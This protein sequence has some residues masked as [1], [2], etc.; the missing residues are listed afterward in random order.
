[1]YTLSLLLLTLFSLYIGV[2]AFFRWDASFLRNMNHAP[3]QALFILAFAVLLAAALLLLRRLLTRLSE[4][5][6]KRTALL[7][8]LILG[9][10]QLLFLAAIR[11]V[12]RYDPLK[13]FDMAV[14][15]LR[16]HTI[17]GTY[18]TGYFARYTNN[19]PLTILTY[20]FLRILSGLGVP[21]TAFMTAVQLVNILC[22]LASVW[23]GYLLMKE[24]R[25]RQ[26][27]VFFL[28][29]CALCPLSYVWAGYFYT[30][31]CSMPFLMG[32]LYLW[33][34]IRKKLTAPEPAGL[35]RLCVLSGL[36]GFVTVFGFKLRATAAIAL[37]A[38]LIDGALLLWRRRK[39]G[40]AGLLGEALRTLA[41]PCL[42]FALTA[43]LSLGFFSTAVKTYVNFDYKNTG[44]PAIH[45]IMMSARWDG[46]FDQND[47]NYTVSFET[48]EEKEAADLAVLKQRIREAGPLGLVTL[49]G[50]KLLNTW[51][52]GTDTYQAE[53]SYARYGKLYDYLLGYKSGFLTIYAQA[54][55]ALQLLVIGLASFSAWRKLRRHEKMPGLF[56]VQLTL[57]GGMA[58]H[59]L[60]E[61]NP[62]YSIGFTYLCLMLLADGLTEF[63]KA[64]PEYTL[65]G[66]LWLAPA[67]GTVL[68]ALLL[69]LAKK[70]LVDTPIEAS[71]Y[72][73]DQYQY[74]GGYDGCVTSYDQTYTQTFTTD[75]PFNRISIRAVN[76]VGDYNQSAFCVR[77]TDDQGQVVYENDR[78][79]S[80]LVT[81]SALYE[82]QLG[83]ILPDGPTTYTFEIWPGYIEGE[84]S[85]E[86]LSY[87]TGNCDLYPGGTLTVAGEEQPKGDLAFA[88]YEYRVT[89]YFSLKQYLV[90]C[91]GM[92]AMAIGITLLSWKKGI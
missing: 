9:L 15:M 5:N 39:E 54:F 36:L 43:A 24:L 14:E 22:I 61:T 42:A 85:L 34:R 33:I 11:P 21:E 92:V 81:R 79:L 6:L 89:T 49:A 41:I 84:N 4:R 86:F 26:N 62:L 73:I 66:R 2:F 23:I 10:G 78:F 28:G 44:F 75:K 70:E 71:D 37:I 32:I 69:V 29:V 17:S 74:A 72:A 68:L 30:A 65:S 64:L 76:T 45:W 52:D 20:W 82:F 19:Y 46:A 59:L 80:G 48:K 31:N 27:A 38:A 58:F 50:R 91:A 25:G 51:V 88:V 67:A 18:E 83:E 13:I 77:L 57:L 40:M 16:T 63:A 47:E 12:L 56:L 90:L 60:W 35:L 87:N 55:R 3:V 8:F 1:M 7:L 53:N